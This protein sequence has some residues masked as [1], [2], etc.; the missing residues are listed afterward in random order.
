MSS[1]PAHGASL[2]QEQPA[3]QN[4]T[5]SPLAHEKQVDEQR[6][7]SDGSHDGKEHKKRN[8]PVDGEYVDHFEGMS[9]EDLA[10]MERKLLWKV[11]LRLLIPFVLVRALSL[12]HEP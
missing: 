10:K 2:A 7:S 5:S 8:H 1:E 11:D 3:Q 9:E 6:D 4:V 12:L